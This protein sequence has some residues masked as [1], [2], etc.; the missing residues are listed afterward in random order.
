VFL[1][2]LGLKFTG[3]V[4]LTLE[5]TERHV[6]GLFHALD[7][8]LLPLVSHRQVNSVTECRYG[9]GRKGGKIR[10]EEKLRRNFMS[11]ELRHPHVNW[12][13]PKEAWIFSNASEK[14]VENKQLEDFEALETR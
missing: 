1:S 3:L 9:G 10:R 12:L 6:H 11:V 2:L 5:L 7:L 14:P 4:H 13:W 8:I